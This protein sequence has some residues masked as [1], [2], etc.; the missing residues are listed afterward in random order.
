MKST[1]SLFAAACSILSQLEVLV[2]ELSDGEYRAPADILHSATIGQH[3]R[4]TLE[5]FICLQNGVATGLVNYDARAHNRD[6]ETARE[7]A[8]T[9]LQAVKRFLGEQ[10]PRDELW[11]ASDYSAHLDEP[12]RIV[13]NFQR[14]LAYNI[15]H[16]IHH[17]ALIRI[18]LKEIAPHLR[19]PRNFGVAVSTLRHQSSS[20]VFAG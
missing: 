1:C 20:P 5:F 17:M 9:T 7:L 12:V 18:G 8:L 2:Q 3:V 11:L 16:A 15:E 6:L 10:P 14:E 4:H 19:V 13:T